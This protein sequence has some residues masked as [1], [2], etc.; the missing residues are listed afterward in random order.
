ML[1]LIIAATAT[2]FAGTTG[3][4]SGTV[5]DFS[6][7]DKLAGVN[8]IVEGT[9]LTTV[10]DKNGY[11]V[12]TSVPPGEYKVTASLVGYSDFQLSKV[13]VVMDVTT[14]VECTLSQAVANEETVVIKESRPMIQHDVIP[15]TYIVD[16]NQEQ[17]IRSQPTDMYQTPALVLTQPGVV[18]DE[19][20]Y[21]HIRGGRGNEIAY[22]LDGI[23]ITEPVTNGFGT[24]IV[25]VGL[26]KMEMFTGG[27]RPEYGNAVSGVFNQVVKTGKT[28]PGYT[29]EFTGGSDSFSGTY[30]QI[31]G[32]GKNFDYYLGGYVWHSDFQGLQYNEVGCGDYIGKFNYDL[33]LKNKLTFLSGSG[34]ATYQF[35]ETHTQT[36]G[37]LGIVTVPEQRDLSHQAYGLNALTWTHTLSPAAFF[38]LRPY[39]FHN[40][41][42]LDSL[43]PN[44]GMWW[45]AGSATTGLQFDY[46]NQL[47]E[48]H[49]IKAGGIRM[50]SNNNYWVNIPDMG[51]EYTANTDTT[52]T[53]MYVQDQMKLND[54]WRA[55]A[56]V[57]Y[58]L[59][60][61]DKVENPDSSE[62]QVSPRFGVSYAVNPKTNLRFSY[63]SMIQFVHTQAVERIYTDPEWLDYL[64]LG[65]S[66]LKPERSTQY[67]IGWERQVSNDYSLQVTPFYR[68]MKDMLQYRSLNEDDSTAP[69]YVFDNLGKG[70]SQ[71]LELLFKKRA[72]KNWSGWLAYTYSIAKAESSSMQSTVDPGQMQYVDW[73]QRH[74]AVLV[75]NYSKDKWN[76]SFL[77]EYGSG[78]PWYL[79][80]DS[81]PNTRRT[82][83]HTTLSVNL[84]R[85]IKGGWIPQGEVHLGIA[86]LLNSHTVIDR[87]TDGAPTAEVE[88]RF[89]SLSYLRRF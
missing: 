89:I 55:E 8:V 10:T 30:P 17:M 23:P 41:W 43:H 35:P 1:P 38:T 69:P 3:I 77:G 71:G 44:M 60:H 18:A 84:S 45:D 2:V 33:G 48:R 75:L 70:S 62:S 59:M 87:G 52:Q 81:V 9:N 26:D 85:E 24:N 83:S 50:A 15:T 51:Y 56:G 7:G 79:Q 27:Y 12:I 76:Y 82:G 73:D 16:T 74:T 22:L 32:A 64:G 5:T 53:G 57:R 37:P 39:F 68:Q 36:Y 13:N 29:L 80:A 49:L 28:A 88:P 20:G 78:L 72:S 25:T 19:G 66:D 47:S 65:N 54:K 86:N 4:I 61:Y 46:T 14:T 67:D 6:T 40:E 31:G 34:D 63:G 42:N 58:D 21:P 11:F